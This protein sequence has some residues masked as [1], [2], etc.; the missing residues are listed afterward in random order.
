MDAIE[1]KGNW[2]RGFAL[3]IHTK[4]SVCIGEHDDGSPAFDTI[5]TEMGEL[6][7]RLKYRQDE[8]AVRLLVQKVNECISGIGS[9]SAIIPAPPSRLDRVFQP[10]FLVGRA[11]AA[12]H[13]VRF[14]EN[15]LLKT[16][17]TMEMKLLRDFQRK[18]GILSKAIRYNPIH[19]LRGRDVLVLDDLCQTGATL[20]V[21]TDVLRKQAGVRRVCVLTLTKTRK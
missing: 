9:F 19:D 20:S 21:V 18:V 8:G 2:E 1:I 14:I 16:Q 11:L 7:N 6:V 17:A 10:V 3:D 5:R 12:M 15:A 13:R 4:S